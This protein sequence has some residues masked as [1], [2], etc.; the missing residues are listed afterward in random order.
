MEFH[1]RSSDRFVRSVSILDPFVRVCIHSSVKHCPRMNGERDI[2]LFSQEDVIIKPGERKLIPTDTKIQWKNFHQ[3]SI[4][5]PLKGTPFYKQ[6]IIPQWIV[7]NSLDE[8]ISNYI[9]IHNNKDEDI[10]V[11]LGEPVARVIL[12]CA[13]GYNCAT[14]QSDWLGLQAE[15]SD[16]KVYRHLP[17]CP[18]TQS[19]LPLSHFRN[20]LYP[21]FNNFH[22]MCHI[23]APLLKEKLSSMKVYCAEGTS[24]PPLW[25][26]PSDILVCL[27]DK[28]VLS[29]GENIVD[30]GGVRI[31]CC[32]PLEVEWPVYGTVLAKN[33]PVK[34]HRLVR[35]DEL[36]SLK[37][38]WDTTAHGLN[39]TM[40]EAGTPVARIR[41][42]LRID[43]TSTRFNNTLFC[44]GEERATEFHARVGECLEFYRRPDGET[45]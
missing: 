42:A 37:I 17:F 15:E 1:R 27:Q 14:T 8:D 29:G 9:H 2:V 25:I 33:C 36:K 22:E 11:T 3:Y 34:Q 30:V 20:P 5:F 16:G 39:G 24:Y 7:T 35:M 21:T 6:K 13:A 41:S 4:I 18:I 40:L 32:E 19:D 45:Q 44:E 12:D 26:S 38:F 43:L 28:V 31:D 10:K 23:N